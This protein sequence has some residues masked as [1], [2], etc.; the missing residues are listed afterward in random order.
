MT[1][2]AVAKSIGGPIAVSQVRPPPCASLSLLRA[3]LSVRQKY[4]VQSTGIWERIRRA[5]A[6]APD[7]SNGVPLN[8][9]FRNPP[10]GANDPRA[11]DD[12]VSVP[13]ADLADNPY[14]RRDVRRAYPKLSV[15][16]PADVVGLL[17][18]G[19]R[20]APR[21]E[22]LGSGEEGE[23]R[24]VEVKKEGEKGLAAYFAGEEK[25]VGAVL[26]EGG[27]PPLPVSMARRSAN[28]RK[29]YVLE[30]EQTYGDE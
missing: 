28:T 8:P 16:R 5:L 14:W 1:S 7:R 21:P 25:A 20:S 11:Y 6:V 30:E 12:P 18:V 24:L 9:Q 19:S 27:M 29:T 17:S 3:D 4:T 15:V 13:A 2:K 26:G 22:R 23:K 10:P